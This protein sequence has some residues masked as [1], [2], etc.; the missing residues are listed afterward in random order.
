MGGEYK[1]SYQQLMFTPTAHVNNEK[2]EGYQNKSG[3]KNV[4]MY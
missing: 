1:G 3:I 4:L 2:D